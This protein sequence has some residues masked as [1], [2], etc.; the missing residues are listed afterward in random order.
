MSKSL[1]YI[2]CPY[3]PQQILEVIEMNKTVQELTGNEL[4][5]LIQS[6]VESANALQ[7]DIIR[8]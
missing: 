2:P 1:S 6:S 5:T 3:I 7:T 8:K 4:I